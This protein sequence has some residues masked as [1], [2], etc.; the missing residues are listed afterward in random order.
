MNIRNVLISQ[1]KPADNERNPY[2]DLT[3]KFKID[4]HF[5]KFIRI[6]GLSASEF[7]KFR[8]PLEEHNAIILTS[9]LAVD[10]FFR[11]AKHMRFEVP[12]EMKYF[13]LS[14]STALYLQK[15]TQFRKRKIFFSNNDF[16]ELVRLMKKHNGGKFLFACSSAHKPAYPLLLD[17]GE[18]QYS[19]AILYRTVPA[20]LSKLDISD[21]DMIVFFSPVGIESLF[22]NFPDFKQGETH[23]ACYGSATAKAVKEHG[24]KLSLSAPTTNAPSMT[25][26]LEDYFL[27]ISKQKKA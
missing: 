1:H 3:K 9:R 26:A 5:H 2:S 27:K 7:R 16:T 15:Y 8:I 14:E 10:H 6:E 13:C 23:I 20:N 22:S 25:M 21:Y 24:L 18:I 19:K 12:D 11:V 4:F 17:Q